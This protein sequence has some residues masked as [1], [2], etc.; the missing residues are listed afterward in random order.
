MPPWPGM[1]FP[2][3]FIPAMRLNLDSTKSPIV[4]NIP[5]IKA[6]EVQISIDFSLKLGLAL[7]YNFEIK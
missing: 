7:M 2:L 5:T 4:P 3:S 6:I 1:I